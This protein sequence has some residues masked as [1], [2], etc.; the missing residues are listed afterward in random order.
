MAK[1][2][3]S[4]EELQSGLKAVG[5]LGGII[6]SGARRDSPFGADF[7]RKELPVVAPLPEK[8][9]PSALESKTELP[10]L[11]PEL[12]EPQEPALRNLSRA[13]FPKKALKAKENK[14]PE[15]S[16]RVFEERVTLQMPAAMRDD[17][18]FLATVLQR[19]KTDKKQRITANTVMRVAIQFMLD[20]F[21]IRDGDVANTE[22]ELLE[23][24]KRKILRV[25]AP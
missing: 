19:R 3:I 2:Q 9:P 21:K 8:A 12:V 18:N 25:S 11:R 13:P 6:S 14:D 20:E 16:P 15:P 17:V 23:L 4:E 10:L 24:T 22:E 1:G 7:V 5:G